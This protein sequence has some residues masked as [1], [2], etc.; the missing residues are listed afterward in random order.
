MMETTSESTFAGGADD[1]HV[2][3]HAMSYVRMD[4]PRRTVTGR[5][6]EAG[7]VV[8][9]LS[10]GPYER[11]S[12]QAAFTAAAT[13]ERLRRRAASSSSQRR[14]R[15][16]SESKE[17]ENANIDNGLPISE[18]EASTFKLIGARQQSDTWELEE[19]Q[20]VEGNKALVQWKAVRVSQNHQQH[21][22]EAW[23]AQ[24]KHE[25]VVTGSSS[26]DRIFTFKPT[27]EL[28]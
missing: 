24:I 21:F 12:Y 25:R 23:Q 22:R 8:P 6:Q 3:K 11:P 18:E 20:Q 10:L 5:V 13:E 27:W 17:A 19:I 28:K 1:D 15:K 7:V 14:S 9:G 26:Q 16:S 2:S 4:R